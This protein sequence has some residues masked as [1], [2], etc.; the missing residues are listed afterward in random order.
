MAER[1][2]YDARKHS[3]DRMVAK[4][5]RDFAFSREH[6]G[7]NLFTFKRTDKNLMIRVFSVSFLRMTITIVCYVI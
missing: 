5:A 1:F 7:G 6:N 3:R 4:Y 2:R